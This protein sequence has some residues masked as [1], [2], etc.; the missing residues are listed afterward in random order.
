M[1][2]PCTPSPHKMAKTS[3]T[4]CRFT[5]MPFSSR[6]CENRTSGETPLQRGL[7]DS[8]AARSVVSFW[9]VFFVVQAGRL[10]AGK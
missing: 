4:C 7:K 5:W 3:R 6:V 1:T 9:V 10:E 2:T 8:V